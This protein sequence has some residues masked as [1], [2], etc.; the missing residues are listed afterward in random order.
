MQFMKTP[1][2]LLATSLLLL[3]LGASSPLL[4]AAETPTPSKPN[5]L[6]I[7]SDDHALRTISAYDGAINKTPNIDR[8]AHEGAVFDNWFVGNSICCPCRASLMTGKHSTANGV[9]G[10]SS[11]WNGN[12]WVYS[13]E[14]GKAGYQTALIGKWHLKGNPTDEFQHW[15]ILTG[16]GGQGSY[17]NTEFLS[18]AG[19]SKPDGYSTDIITDKS[20]D[21]LKNRDKSK[22]FLLEVHFKAPHTPRTPNLPDM[23]S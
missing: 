17:Y 19:S 6:F 21:W 18:Q 2:H 9:T 13:R 8:L 7:L 20:I 23:G 1:R 22:P 11:A 16:D 12:Q 10:N 3:L 15:E 5:I 4:R 14:I